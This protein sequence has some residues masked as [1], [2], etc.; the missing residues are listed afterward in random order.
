M[1]K[2][3]ANTLSSGDNPLAAALELM[4]NEG[5]SSLPVLD[6]QN[7]VIGNI[8]Q[9]DVRVGYFYPIYLLEDTD[10]YS[11]SPSP[12]HSHFYDLRVFTSS[13]SS[14]LNAASMT[15]KTLSLFSTWTPS[16]HSPTQLPS[17]WQRVLTACGL[18]TRPHPR[19]LVH[20]HQR[21]LRLFSCRLP[22]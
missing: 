16:A 17:W 9:V 12:L 13:P 15:V 6:A 14:S 1:S 22:P 11:F 5:V 18:W 7:N 4:N 20:L 8:S 2:T 19:L 3:R 10:C 21:S